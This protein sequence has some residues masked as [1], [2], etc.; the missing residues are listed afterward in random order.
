MNNIKIKW[1]GEEFK[2]A[3]YE[4]IEENLDNAAEHVESIAKSYC[5]VDTGNLQ[6]SIEI[7]SDKMSR[8]IG[9]DV[10][11]ALYVELGTQH[12]AAQPYLRPAIDEPEVIRLMTRPMND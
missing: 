1:Y 7:N 11:Y 8:T 5:P 4:H 10:E 6:D 12:M 9:S 2:K 3:L